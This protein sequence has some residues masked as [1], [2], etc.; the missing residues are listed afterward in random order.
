MRRLFLIG[1][2]RRLGR[3]GLLPVAC[4]ALFGLAGAAY[5]QK[6]ATQAPVTHEVRPGD[7][8]FKIARQVLRPG[9]NIWQMVL[10]IYR[11]NPDAFVGGNINH[12]PVGRVL[13][14]PTPE[15]A[16]AVDALQAG[17]EVQALS[18][19]RPIAPAPSAAPSAPATR[20]KPAAIPEKPHRPAMAPTLSTTQAQAQY[21]Q[22]LLLERQGNLSGAFEA[23]MAAGQSGNGQAQK[24]LGDFYNM[25]NA[26]VQR[27]YETALKWYQKA[28][29][30]GVEIPKPLTP[31]IRP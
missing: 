17:R 24:K 4:V 8:L 22:G 9:V 26:A 31:G 7:S 29:D 25:G 12:L 14:I 5:A 21:Q 18:S 30:Q 28:R 19:A 3:F 6:P 20:P 10:A 2:L 27:D 23:Y 11:A 13:T 16:T 1:A 15:A